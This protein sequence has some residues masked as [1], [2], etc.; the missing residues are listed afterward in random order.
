SYLNGNIPDSFITQL[1]II[2]GVTILFMLS[3]M[4]GIGR[5]IKWLSNTNIVMAVLLLLFVLFAGPTTFLLNL[6]TS[7]L[8]NYLEF[9]PQMSFR[10]AP[11]NETN[12]AWIQDWTIFYWAW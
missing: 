8:G 1:I 3:A 4:S 11:F 9:L 5:G 10:M 12:E 6:L 2:V 7:S